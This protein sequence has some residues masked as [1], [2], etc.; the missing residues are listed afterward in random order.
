MINVRKMEIQ[1]GVAVIQEKEILKIVT[2]IYQQKKKERIAL[3][4]RE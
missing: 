4:L 3:E 1:R 2:Q